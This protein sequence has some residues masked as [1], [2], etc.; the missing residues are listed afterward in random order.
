LEFHNLFYVVELRMAMNQAIDFYARRYL[1]DDDDST[2]ITLTRVERNDVTG[3][4]IPTYEYA[5]PT[6]CLW[7]NRV[8]TE[9]SVSGVKLTGTISD[10]FTLG[11]VVTGGTSGATGLLSYSGATYIRV[12][13]VDGTFVVGE[14]AT[15]VSTETC[16]A[17]TA[18]E[19]EPAGDATFP[20][21]NV[22]DPRDWRVI[23]AYA[24][25]L[26]LKE[27]Y[28]EVVE[29]LRLRLDYQ[30][31]QDNVTADTDTIMI[32]PDE[33][34]AVAATFLPFNKIESNKLVSKFND[35]LAIREMV[36]QRPP[37]HPKPNA[38]KCW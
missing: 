15:G 12:R 27:G 31:I 10:T 24:P 20:E 37:V 25:Q 35:C 21:E 6:T 19:Y 1:L 8:T 30:C 3:S 28:Y 34:I 26:V 38:R 11:E 18:V 23:R 32:P 4:Y 9:D 16:S 2:T 36:R 33:F 29:D 22:V 7:L 5:L 14:T 17:I 13:E